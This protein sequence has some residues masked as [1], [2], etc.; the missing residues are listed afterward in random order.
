[1]VGGVYGRAEAPGLVRFFLST[2]TKGGVKVSAQTALRSSAYH[3]L[4]HLA[5]GWTIKDNK[6]GEPA[7]IPIASVNEGLASVFSET[8]TDQ[9]FPLANDYPNNVHQWFDEVMKLPIDANYGHWVAG[10][11][12][13]GRSV[14]GYRL[15]RYIIHQAQKRT[16]KSVIELSK[17]DPNAVLDLLSK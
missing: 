8:Y 16:G 11:H 17:M 7:G 3:E 13:D 9:Y 5:I 6:F 2:A 12:P 15:G 14:I 10:F 1:M 4:H